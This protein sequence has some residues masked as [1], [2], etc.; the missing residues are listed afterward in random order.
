MSLSRLAVRLAAVQSILNATLAGSRVFDSRIAPFDFMNAEDRKPLVI[1]LTDDDNSEIMGRDT[2][3]GQRSLD[4]VI[5]IAVAKPVMM[6]GGVTDIEIPDTDNGYELILDIL[7]A[8]IEKALR[9]YPGTW[10]D[11]FRSLVSRYRNTVSR[12][13]ADQQKGIKFAARQI[14]YTIEP[15]ADP[16]ADRAAETGSVWKRFVDAL[17]A[18]PDLAAVAPI[19]AAE[20]SAGTLLEWQ[21]AQADLGLTDAEIRGIGLSPAFEPTPQNPNDTEVPPPVS[22]VTAGRYTITAPLADQNFPSKNA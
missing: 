3:A 20:M 9:V 11:I 2:V 10:P 21:K 22:Q 5:E 16:P 12:R 19:F 13:T 4:L 7:E 15:L 17:A 18:T 14:I 8:Q 6:E 1:V